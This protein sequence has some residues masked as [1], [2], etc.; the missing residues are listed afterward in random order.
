MDNHSDLGLEMTFAL[1]VEVGFC[2]RIDEQHSGAQLGCLGEIVR[3]P[4][5]KPTG[6]T[7]D[8]SRE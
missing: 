6:D 5:R 4:T 7:T 1:T 2:G 8:L 3:P